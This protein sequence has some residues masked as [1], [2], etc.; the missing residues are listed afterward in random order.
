MRGSVV[1]TASQVMN[2]ERDKRRAVQLGLSNNRCLETV[3]GSAGK[4]LTS[5]MCSCVCVVGW[6]GW[7]GVCMHAC[8]DACVF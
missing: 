1:Q 3:L 7:R 2:S 8:V 4:K 5:C 6:G